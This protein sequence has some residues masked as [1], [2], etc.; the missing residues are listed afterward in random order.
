MGSGSGRLLEGVGATFGNGRLTA[1]IGRNGAGKSTLLRALAGLNRSYGGEIL[2]DGTDLRRLGA[3]RLAKAVAVVTTQRTRIPNLSCRQVVAIGRAPY[4]DWLGRLG[5]RDRRIVDAA[6][7]QVGMADY[8]S[9]T[10]DKMSDGECQRIMIARAL[11]QD[12][13][14]ILL[15]EPTSFLDLPNRYQLA[16]L[17]Q[18]LAHEQGKCVLFSTHELDVAMRL[19]DDIALIDDG[20]LYHLPVAEMAASGH[21]SRLFGTAAM[22]DYGFLSP[23]D[24]NG[25]DNIQ[26]KTTGND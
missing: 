10:M 2:L 9:R 8:A 21:L 12:T 1:L 4:T 3:P 14:T 13:P 23:Q 6:L 17:L 19:C 20:R 18:H 7:D 22:P 5:D 26:G 25:K 11:A 16:E 15:D 24:G